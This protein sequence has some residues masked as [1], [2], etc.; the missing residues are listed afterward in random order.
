V[1]RHR[2]LIAAPREAQIMATGRNGPYGPWIPDLDPAERIARFR[3]LASLAA[4][5][6]GS[7]H[8][9]VVALRRAETDP[10]AWA[11]ARTLLEAVPAL[12]QRR[13]LS[14]YAAV[15]SPMRNSV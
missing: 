11:T 14:T 7:G 4:L 3:S 12:T 10:G 8:H 13:L 9:L 5:L 6:L 1:P 2:T 15:H